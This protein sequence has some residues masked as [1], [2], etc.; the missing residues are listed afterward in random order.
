MQEREV[1]HYLSEIARLL[2][3]GGEMYATF[4]LLNDEANRLISQGHSSQ[5]FVSFD[6]DRIKVISLAIPDAAIGYDETVIVNA[7]RGAGLEV[8]EIR[9][10]SWCGR[11][12]FDYQDVLFA[13]KQ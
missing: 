9:R 4:F 13:R 7:V 8:A 10:G 6:G 1:L 11:T 2:R 5:K 3:T 12:G